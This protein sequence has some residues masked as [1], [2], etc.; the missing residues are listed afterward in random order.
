MEFTNFPIAG[1]TGHTL[2]PDVPVDHGAGAELTVAI[3]QTD[4]SVDVTVA[5]GGAVLK[6]ILTGYVTYDAASSE[7]VHEITRLVDGQPKEWY[8]LLANEREL[9]PQ[10]MPHPA[11]IRYSFPDSQARFRTAIERT[12]PSGE[13]DS[14]PLP[15]LKTPRGTQVRP[16]S[17][18]EL[19]NQLLAGDGA[20]LV[21]GG[22]QIGTLNAT[23]QV[24]VGSRHLQNYSAIDD[25]L[26]I[27]ADPTDDGAALPANRPIA[28]VYLP[29]ETTDAN[30]PV[31]G[32]TDYA[33]HGS[34]SS[35]RYKIDH[36]D[37][38][39][40]HSVV[41]H[42]EDN[43]TTQ[44]RRFE[45]DRF[46][47]WA[48]FRSSLR[49]L[50]KNWHRS[51]FLP[52]PLRTHEF[53]TDLYTDLYPA[54]HT[55]DLTGYPTPGRSIPPPDPTILGYATG[56]QQGE[57]R[58]T[59][60]YNVQR[61]K[62][63]LNRE[64]SDS[65]AT[66]PLRNFSDFD[67]DGADGLEEYAKRVTAKEFFYNKNDVTGEESDS[68]AVRF[69]R[70]HAGFTGLLTVARTYPLNRWFSNMSTLS[71]PIST[72]YARAT[73]PGDATFQAHS[74]GALNTLARTETARRLVEQSAAET[75]G[76]VITF[77]GALMDAEMFAGD[78]SQNTSCNGD[79]DYKQQVRTKFG[80]DCSR[81]DDQAYADARGHGRCY[82]QNGSKT[83]AAANL[84]YI[85][86]IHWYNYGVYI[87]NGY[88]K[89]DFVTHPPGRNGW[90]VNASP[91]TVPQMHVKVDG[92]NW[93]STQNVTPNAA[94]NWR[95]SHNFRASELSRDTAGN[96]SHLDFPVEK[97]RRLQTLRYKTGDVGTSDT[98][99][100]TVLGVLSG[101]GTRV[102]V[103]SRLNTFEQIANNILG[104]DNVS[105]VSGTTDR[106]DLTL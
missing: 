74:I 28:H 10:L 8:P 33:P 88:A 91:P 84:T 26:A 73:F 92:G 102:R 53:V 5:G 71:D 25:P 42:Y 70:E 76:Q 40:V 89:G 93:K 51:G 55:A 14:T 11:E 20:L 77:E 13:D 52:T 46:E 61:L 32:A 15:K 50:Y 100:I 9:N 78:G 106:W 64:A 29:S 41:L 81:V 57:E 35:N 18:D 66:S 99:G 38:E 69:T 94:Q 62:F 59:Y 82:S 87:R 56:E 85:Q 90:V 63:K 104:A 83:L 17:R 2:G 80:A 75:R 96:R 86:I 45:L 30:D 3:D 48:L 103:R 67:Y 16:T 97:V 36:G 39:S 12:L 95:V 6:A 37:V 7:V 19:L 43:G 4:L 65:F 22:T 58:P 1:A 60:E 21:S 44:K 24:S 34:W 23:E 68:L 101:G 79:A 31:D 72:N 98:G 54:N 49:W 27:V 47:K 105:E